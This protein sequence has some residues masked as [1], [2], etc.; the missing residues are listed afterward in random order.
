[1]REAVCDAPL[2][3]W[4]LCGFQPYNQTPANAV[5]QHLLPLNPCN[6]TRGY[7]I[8]YDREASSPLDQQP[9]L[10]VK[11]YA[12]LMRHGLHDGPV[13]PLAATSKHSARLALQKTPNYL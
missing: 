7:Y 2:R 8:Q 5:Q 6:T 3:L 13:P 12:L 9:A 10:S 4:E 1:M 11:P